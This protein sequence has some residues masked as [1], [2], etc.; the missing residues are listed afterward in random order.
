MTSA[1]D[2]LP[3]ERRKLALAA[4]AKLHAL[5]AK[6]EPP[7]SEDSEEAAAGTAEWLALE[8]AIAALA[9]DDVGASRPA[10]VS[11]IRPTGGS[12]AG[13]VE[14]LFAW[15][16]KPVARFPMEAAELLVARF[17]K[18][19]DGKREREESEAKSVESRRFW[20]TSFA[21]YARTMGPKEAAAAAERAAVEWHRRFCD[22]CDDDVAHPG[23]ARD[24]PN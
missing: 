22:E 16:T 12:P 3:P 15:L 6:L 20:E 10:E 4:H 18:Y 5:W 13:A 24:V 9:R 19:E 14:L 1:F 7:E 21:A 17:E 2:E 23:E 8:E 11:P